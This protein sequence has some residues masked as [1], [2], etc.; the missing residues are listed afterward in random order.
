MTASQAVWRFGWFRAK[1]TSA[2]QKLNIEPKDTS[3]MSVLSSRLFIAF[4]IVIGMKY[5]HLYTINKSGRIS[6]LLRY[7]YPH[8]PKSIGGRNPRR[9]DNPTGRGQLKRGLVKPL[10]YT[11]K[12]WGLKIYSRFYLFSLRQ[13][14]W[15]L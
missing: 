15:S 14:Y 11:P 7:S 13:Y 10:L 6:L 12:Y 2:T 5:F 8:P 1:I 9:M 3:E 4:R